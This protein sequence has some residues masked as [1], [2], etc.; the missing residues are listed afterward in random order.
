MQTRPDLQPLLNRFEQDLVLRRFRPAT[1]RNYLLY[2][3]LY[4]HCKRPVVWFL[5]VRVRDRGRWSY[6]GR[7]RS[8]R[9][10][11]RSAFGGRAGT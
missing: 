9:R 2:A 11:L 8:G 7:Q 5:S 10:S 6:D 3:R 4:L 1:R